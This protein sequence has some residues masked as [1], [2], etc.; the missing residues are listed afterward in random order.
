MSILPGHHKNVLDAKGRVSL[1]SVFRR[2]LSEGPFVLLQWKGSLHLTLLTEEGW[3]NAER[4]L[5]EHRRATRDGGR[6]LRALSQRATSVTIDKQGRIRIPDWLLEL[7]GLTEAIVFIGASD[8]I[9]LWDP[10][11]LVQDTRAAD[12]SDDN[13]EQDT[14]SWAEC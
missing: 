3:A 6:A 1:P 7:A 12:E 5:L 11:R 4:K 14:F 13:L 9:E 8:R 2:A 10:A